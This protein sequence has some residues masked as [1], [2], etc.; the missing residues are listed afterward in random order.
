[1]VVRL[2]RGHHRAS[3]IDLQPN[4]RNVRQPLE[5]G[6]ESGPCGAR[7]RRVATGWLG[8]IAPNRPSP[9]SGHRPNHPYKS[10]ARSAFGPSPHSRD[11]DS[12]AKPVR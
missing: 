3:A 9:Q 1:V 12:R 6:A 4:R 11:P 2:L 10:R 8:A 7:S 5:Q